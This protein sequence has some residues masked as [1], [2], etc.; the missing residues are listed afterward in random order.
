MFYSAHAFSE[1]MAEA[2]QRGKP[3]NLDGTVGTKDRRQQ[4]TLLHIFVAKIHS[5]IVVAVGD[6]RPMKVV[7]IHRRHAHEKIQI[8]FL[9]LFYCGS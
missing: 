8:A 5:P 3:G 4:G 9:K 6:N 7:R 2:R 1:E